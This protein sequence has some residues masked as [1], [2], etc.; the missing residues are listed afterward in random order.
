MDMILK[1]Y[2]SGALLS[3]FMLLFIFLK[4]R[5][6]EEDGGIPNDRETSSGFILAC[7]IIMLMFSSFSW[8]GAIFLLAK[9]AHEI[10]NGID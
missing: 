4:S 10:K 9:R 2:F 6:W 5:P 1:F 7:I 3:F 8:V